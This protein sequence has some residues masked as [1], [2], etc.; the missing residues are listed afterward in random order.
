VRKHKID[1]ARVLEG[2]AD[3]VVVDRI[4]ESDAP[5]VRLLILGSDRSGR[6]LGVV[7]GEEDE[8]LV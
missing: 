1:R 3:P 6:V 7:A 5:A 8:R 4:G 2:L